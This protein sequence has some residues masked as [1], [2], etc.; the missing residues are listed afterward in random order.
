MKL[1]KR[2]AAHFIYDCKD[3][4]CIARIE[5][6]ELNPGWA[7]PKPSQGAPEITWARP[8][9]IDWNMWQHGIDPD[10]WRRV[11]RGIII[12]PPPKTPP[13]QP[14]S[15]PVSAPPILVGTP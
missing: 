12:Q 4:V 5:F 8:H 15:S 2:C 1:S 3:P 13:A 11:K 14:A 10:A 9:L 6:N 7:A